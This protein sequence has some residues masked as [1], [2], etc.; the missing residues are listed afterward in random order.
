LLNGDNQ[1]GFQRHYKNVVKG[2]QAQ[3]K[4]NLQVSVFM[5]VWRSNFTFAA[6]KTGINSMVA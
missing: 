2:N 1:G 4:Y 5:A 3:N 6:L